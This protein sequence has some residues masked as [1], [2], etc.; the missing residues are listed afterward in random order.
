MHDIKK[1]MLATITKGLARKSIVKCS[2]WALEYRYLEIDIPILDNNNNP[3]LDTKGEPITRKEV[4]KWSFEDFPFLRDMHDSEAEMNIGKKAAQMGYTETVLNRTLFNVDIKNRSCLY[5]LPSEK[6]DA[7]DFSAS[8]FNPAIEMSPHLEELFNDVANVGHKRAG[9]ANIYI[10]GAMSRKGLKSIPVSCIVID[11]RDEMPPTHI[12][13][14]LQRSAGQAHRETWQISTPTYPEYGIDGEYLLS[15]QNHFFFR[16]PHCSKLTELIFPDC[17]KITAE[18]VTDPTIK[19]SHIICKECQHPLNHQ[20]KR[21]WLN[22]NSQWVEG[23]GGRDVKGWYINQLYSPRLEP[24]KFAEASIKALT[25]PGEDQ[26]LHNSMMGVAHVVE[27]AGV[28]DEQIQNCIKAFSIFTKGYQGT[29]RVTM[30]IDIGWPMCHVEIDEWLPPTGVINDINLASIPRVIFI[31]TIQN[32]DDLKRIFLD[33]QVTFAVLDSQ[34]ERRI[35]LDFCKS[36]PGRARMCNY[37]V[38]VEGKTINLST[39]EPRLSV[40]RTSWLDLSLG[41]FKH[42]DTNNNPHILLPVNT[43]E[44]YKNHIKNQIRIYEKDKNGQQIGRYITPK[45]QDHYGHARNYAEIALQMC[46]SLGAT[47]NITTTI[48]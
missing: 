25:D 33:Y 32:F 15:S 47:Q 12:P 31:E 18:K 26:E 38:G 46:A 44:E 48:L 9:S 22:N 2:D 27:G 34:P 6:P 41:R 37:T 5:L 17:L 30:G 11:E 3:L 45:G 24:W 28:T 14:A 8:R 10:R 20:E 13:L 35:A 4:K 16:C 36:L 19:Q 39:S 29:R 40:D 42:L 43:P 21:S 23:I 7:R 1:L